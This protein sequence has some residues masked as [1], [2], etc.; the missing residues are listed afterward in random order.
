MGAPEMPET[1]TGRG[2][3][4]SHDHVALFYDGDQEFLDEVMQFI[5]PALD[6]GEPVA[7]AV[8]PERGRLLAGPLHGSASG[9]RILDMFE[10]GRNPARII[11]EVEALRADHVQLHYVGEPVWAGRSPEEIREVTKHEALINLAWSDAPIRA[12][13]AYD[14]ASLG[15]DVLDGAE[16]THPWVIRHGRRSS[17]KLYGGP[18][19]PSGCD[20][21]LALPPDEARSM[22]FGI[23]DLFKLRS[24]VG[25]V[26]QDAG[27]GD[28][29]T[30]DLMLIT[31][32]LSTNAI[33][34]GDGTGVLHAWR[35]RRQVVCQVDDHGQIEDPLAGR[36]RPVPRGTGGLGLWIVNQLC[37]LVEVRS[38]ERGTTVRAHLGLV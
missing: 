8:P 19:I 31:S 34:H 33:R 13:C 17:S 6:R 37:D 35:E 12:L 14:A 26:A 2:G 22:R 38:G 25:R 5:A 27:L 7:V 10:L 18:E 3:C 36:R 23:D 28:D 4:E 20:Q 32:E 30:A 1:E 9:V 21:P 29:Q 11:P 16:R 15:P 24:M